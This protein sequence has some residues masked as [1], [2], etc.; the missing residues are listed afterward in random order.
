MLSWKRAPLPFPLPSPK[1]AK[2]W[3]ARQ[4]KARQ[5][6]VRDEVEVHILPRAEVGPV[7]PL[8]DAVGAGR[9]GALRIGVAVP[10]RPAV[11]GWVER[12]EGRLS[13]A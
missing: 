9:V 1:P 11:G 6:N 12:K 2:G 7:P 4:G 10:V 8:L 13:R 3:K 5:G